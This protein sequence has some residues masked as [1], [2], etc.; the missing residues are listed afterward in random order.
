[1]FEF[2]LGECIGQGQPG[3][4]VYRATSRITGEDFAMKIMPEAQQLMPVERQLAQWWS[5]PGAVLPM[6]ACRTAQGTSVLM[7]LVGHGDLFDRIASQGL[8]QEHE[9][10]KVIKTVALTLASL[11]DHGYCHSDIKPEN[12]LVADPQN[13]SDVR[14]CDFAMACSSKLQGTKDKSGAPLE[15]Q[16]SLPYLAPEVLEGMSGAPRDSWSLGVMCFVMLRGHLP[17]LP[18]NSSKLQIPPLSPNWNQ[19]LPANLVHL[20]QGLLVREP[21]KRLSMAEVLT[22]PWLAAEMDGSC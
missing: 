13:I 20:L 15:V 19:G 14:L 10:R 3:C 22:H 7:P 17:F 8:L 4:R 5:H 1:M 18:F 2:S 6:K 11:H 21:H 16:G 12:V 9:V